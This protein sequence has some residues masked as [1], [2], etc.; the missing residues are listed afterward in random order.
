[1]FL[2]SLDQLRARISQANNPAWFHP[3][4]PTRNAKVKAAQLGLAMLA[5]N[6]YAD[7]STLAREELAKWP[8]YRYP[9]QITG[10]GTQ[11]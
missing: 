9:H 5:T 7:A 3:A 6:S 11:K 2:W 8:R 10:A 1:M 4:E